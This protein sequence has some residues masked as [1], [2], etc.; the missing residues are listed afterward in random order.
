MLF[1]GLFCLCDVYV[2]L[3]DATQEGHFWQADHVLP[4][5]EGGGSAGLEN[6]RTLCTPCHA[7][8]TAKLRIRLKAHK[9][10]LAA[11]GTKD[12][13]SCFMASNATAGGNDG[14][15]TGDGDANGKHS[16]SYMLGSDSPPN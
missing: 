14:A 6:F 4:V 5:I 15:A 9:T 7:Q 11:V 3:C 2:M 16:S 10:A 1:W 12:I 13:R 8:E